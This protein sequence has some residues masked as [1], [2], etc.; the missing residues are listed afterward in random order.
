MKIKK[1]EQ[2]KGVKVGFSV[3]RKLERAVNNAVENLVRAFRVR[4]LHFFMGDSRRM[5]AL[6]KI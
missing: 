3:S 5:C 6:I 4:M 1:K 2:R